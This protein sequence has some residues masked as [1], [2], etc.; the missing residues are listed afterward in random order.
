[1]FPNR[2]S[3]IIMSSK[4]TD[5]LHT[6]PH[7][8]HTPSTDV[9]EE[10]RDNTPSP[11]VDSAI[12]HKLHLRNTSTY[13]S[14]DHLDSGNVTDDTLTSGDDEVQLRRRPLQPSSDGDG[15]SDGGTGFLVRRRPAGQNYMDRR[16]SRSAEHIPEKVVLDQCLVVRSAS[17]TQPRCLD[18]AVALVKGRKVSKHCFFV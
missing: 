9:S 12:R 15:V 13:K 17:G 11:G 18:G 2:D 10:K 8:T 14:A 7:T 16:N 1:M 3:N 5:E 4:P 6:L